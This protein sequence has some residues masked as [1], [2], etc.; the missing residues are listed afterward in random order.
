M[1]TDAILQLLIQNGYIDEQTALDLQDLAKS[2]AKAM[3]QLV[4]DQGILT[5]DDLLAAMAAYQ[6]T[7]AIDLSSMTLETVDVNVSSITQKGLWAPQTNFMVFI[8][9]TQASPVGVNTRLKITSG[10]SGKG[11]ARLYID[12]FCVMKLVGGQDIDYFTMNQGSGQDR[13]L[14]GRNK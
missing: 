14:A 9:S 12:D 13:I 5:E 2:E 10:A 6:D 8:E 3:R 1:V 11:N 7:E 4:I